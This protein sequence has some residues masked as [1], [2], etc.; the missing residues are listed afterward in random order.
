MFSGVS[1]RNF[2]RKRNAKSDTHYLFNIY[3]L[4]VGGPMQ[5]LF[6]RIDPNR[7]RVPAAPYPFR[8]RSMFRLEECIIV[9][10][11]C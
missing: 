2:Y 8:L 11:T 7:F 9:H 1:E 6:A 10:L 5:F 3:K 4:D